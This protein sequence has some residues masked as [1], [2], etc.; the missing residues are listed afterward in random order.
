[1]A[2]D[3]VD[4]RSG[5]T[6]WQGRR[7][8]A[9]AV[10]RLRRDLDTEVL[11]VGA[12]IT[13]A[14]VA[15]ALAEAG[16]KV[17]LVDR[18]GPA[19]GSTTASTA[20]VLYE[21]DTPLTRLVRKL[22][23]ERALRGWRR[24]RLAVDSFAALAERIGLREVARRESLYLA[25]NLLDRAA[26][27]REGEARRAAG[28]ETVFV[29][30]AEL[31]ARHGVRGD[32]ALRSFGHLAIDPRRTTRALLADAIGRGAA[33]YAP[34]DVQEIDADRRGVAVRTADGQRIRARRLVLATGYEFPDGVPRTGHRIV[35]TWAIAT[36]PQRRRLWPGEAMIWEAADPYLY[37][38][39]TADGRVLCGGED[40]P[41]KDEARRDALIDAKSRALQRKLAARIPGLDTRVAFAWTGSFGQS[42]S[43]LP[44][45]GEIPGMPHC[46]AALG[47]GGNGIPYARIAAEVIRAA[48]TGRPDADADLY[49]FPRPAG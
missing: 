42:A 37:I 17:A 32:G 11:V 33:L 8:P 29:P 24:A 38:R 6:V 20:L 39:T 30:R 10:Q 44:S 26:L 18:R 23:R 46:W 1:M 13:G 36:P 48:L 31:A 21:I 27:R 7:G 9:V 12:G 45:I 5:R 15:Q 43:G 28:L 41:F 40:E 47:Y 34:V 14:M 35:S 4:L 3:R 19:A 2:T 25:G 22:G 49:A 16:L